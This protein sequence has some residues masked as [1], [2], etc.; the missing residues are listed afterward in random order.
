LFNQVSISC[1]VE[2]EAKAP[3]L[4]KDALPPLLAQKAREKMGTR[5]G[6]PPTKQ[7]SY[8]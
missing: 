7:H 2:I 1:L 3:P 8:F 6:T 5:Y 4:A